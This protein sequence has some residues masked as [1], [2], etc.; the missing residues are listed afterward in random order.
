MG[1]EKLGDQGHAQADGIDVPGRNLDLHRPPPT[2]RHPFGFGALLSIG[3][4]GRQA[5]NR[6]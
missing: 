6:P 3:P 2:E 1:I 5:E 4:K